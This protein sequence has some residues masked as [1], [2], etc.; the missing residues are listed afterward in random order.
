V[1]DQPIDERDPPAEVAADVAD[2]LAAHATL[3]HH[4][5]SLD[6]ADP[7]LPSRLPEWT[8]GHVLTHISR[9]ADGIVSMLDGMPQYPHGFAGRNGDIEAGASRP[10]AEL[11]DDVEATSASVDERLATHTDWRGTATTLGGDR[12]MAMVPFLRLREVAV[13]HVDLGLGYEFTDLPARYLRKDLRIM[14]MLWRARKPMGMTP[15]PD[16]ALALAPATRLAWFVGRVEI[17]GLE[18][19]DVF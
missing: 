14:E 4:L 13:H 3:V 16:A 11:V 10:W 9:N 5:R 7:S 18:S 15:L 17:E 19:A 6:G 1:D 12:P 8:V 2:V